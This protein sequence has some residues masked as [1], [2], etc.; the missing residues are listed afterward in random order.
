MSVNLATH[1]PAERLAVE[2]DK[3][4]CLIRWEVR[5]LK[6][7]ERQKVARLLLDKHKPHMRELVAAE[8]ARRAGK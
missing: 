1:T 2:S 4:A 6:G 7:K 3:A 5:D 8:L